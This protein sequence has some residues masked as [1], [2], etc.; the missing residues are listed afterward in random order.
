VGQAK[1]GRASLDWAGCW[2][3]STKWETAKWETAKWET[4]KWETA[5]WETAKW[6]TAMSIRRRA[7]GLRSERG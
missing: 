7:R 3:K 2:A 6:E 1:W 5:K 4:A